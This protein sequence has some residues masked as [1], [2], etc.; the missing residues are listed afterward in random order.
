MTSCCATAGHQS[1]VKLLHDP[2]SRAAAWLKACGLAAPGTQV[3]APHIATGGTCRSGARAELQA[4]Q[5]S[6]QTCLL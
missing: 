1:H 5:L 2:G 4:L 6:L 3:A